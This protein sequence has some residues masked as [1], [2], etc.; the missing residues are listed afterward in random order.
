MK[1]LR[2]AVAVT[3]VAAFALAQSAPI[4]AGQAGVPIRGIDVK[5]GKNPGS[6]AAAREIDKKNSSGTT[7]DFNL[8]SREKG[9]KK[10]TS[11]K[12]SVVGDIL[13]R[14]KNGSVGGDVSHRFDEMDSDESARKDK[15]SV[16]GNVT[17]KGQASENPMLGMRRGLFKG[18]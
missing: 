2:I 16:G 7:G 9:D 1:K 11:I 18:H 14:K 13:L 5:L 4:R 15:G 12:S 3:C 17:V 10:T 6:G 8:S